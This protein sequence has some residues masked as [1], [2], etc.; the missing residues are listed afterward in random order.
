LALA[1]G[2]VA[3]SGA[4]VELTRHEFPQYGF[5]ISLPDDWMAVD[6]EGDAATATDQIVSPRFAQL[7]S[8]GWVNAFGVM[9]FQN[10]A[11]PSAAVEIHAGVVEDRRTIDELQDSLGHVSS[12][13]GDD[14]KVTFERRTLP[15]GETLIATTRSR[16]RLLTVDY[17]IFWPKGIARLNF[18]A[19][20]GH[21]PDFAL[22]RAIAV[23]FEEL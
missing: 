21:D 17:W 7:A 13:M 20:G 3:C 14:F 10:T 4:N 2:A 18:I 19:V 9:A 15:A 8:Q 23:S 16:G 11:D 1:L 12:L 22:Y 5:A 6:V